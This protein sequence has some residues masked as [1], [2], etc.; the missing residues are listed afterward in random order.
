MLRRTVLSAQWLPRFAAIATPDAVRALKTRF[1]GTVSVDEFM[2]HLNIKGKG[3]AE[4]LEVL[5]EVGVAHSL[6][7]GL[8]I[9]NPDLI[10]R[11]LRLHERSGH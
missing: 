6:G 10:D 5:L 3:A 8:T 7:K 4:F 2:T 9:G 1:P 11:T